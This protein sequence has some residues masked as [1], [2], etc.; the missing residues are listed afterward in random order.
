MVKWMF[1]LA[2]DD[3]D[4]E[5]AVALQRRTSINI[6]SRCD[7]KLVVVVGEVQIFSMNEP[8]KHVTLTARRWACLDKY[9]DNEAKELIL[10]IQLTAFRAHIGDGYYVSVKSGWDLVD[11]FYIPY[12]QTYLYTR[13][14]CSGISLRLDE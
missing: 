13:P 14:T 9:V 2:E 5:D 1:E 8:T 4:D 6:S 12:G 7:R 10:R 3:I 11:R